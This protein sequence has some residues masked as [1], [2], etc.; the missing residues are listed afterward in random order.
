LRV[1]IELLIQDGRRARPKWVEPVRLL[2]RPLNPLRH[3]AIRRDRTV[4]FVMTPHRCNKAANSLA[5][6]KILC[7]PKQR[8]YPHFLRLV[9]LTVF[10]TLALGLGASGGRFAGGFGSTLLFLGMSASHFG[11]LDYAEQNLAQPILKPTRVRVAPGA[12]LS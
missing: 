7:L 8:V 9:L 12:S 6:M 10:S 5:S 3:L 11:C 4:D 2:R 1:F